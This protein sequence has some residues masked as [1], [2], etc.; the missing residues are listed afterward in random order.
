MS[1]KV[2][3][4]VLRDDKNKVSTAFVY[5][6]IGG[7]G[8]KTLITKAKTRCAEEDEYDPEFGERLAKAK[9]LKKYYMYKQKLAAETVRFLVKEL[10]EARASLEKYNTLAFKAH[11]RLATL[12]NSKYPDEEEVQKEENIQRT[13]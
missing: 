3:V 2:D 7:W 1:K 4:K 8:D 9:A 5:A 13:E 6:D 12:Y 10:N 11:E